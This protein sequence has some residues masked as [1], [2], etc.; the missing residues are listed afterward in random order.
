MGLVIYLIIAWTVICSFFSLQKKLPGVI[1][2]LIFLTV[3]I[4][5]I[6][7]FMIIVL[8][9]RYFTYDSELMKFIVVIIHRDLI[10]PFLLLIFI[11]IISVK[12]TF[13][14]RLSYSFF[15]LFQLLC[16]ERLLSILGYIHNS[17]KWSMLHDLLFDLVIMAISIFTAVVFMKLYSKGQRIHCDLSDL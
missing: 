14:A 11:N 15:T 9:L 7:M 8:R 4:V 1:N 2:I 12:K 10:L 17:Q 6:N 16:T 3:Q 5:Q 13:R